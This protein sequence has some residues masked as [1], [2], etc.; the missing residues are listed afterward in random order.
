[1]FV[2]L[3]VRPLLIVWVGCWG[4]LGLVEANSRRRSRRRRRRR[5][6][7]RRRRRSREVVQ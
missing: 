1:M 5:I 3:F 7:R 2:C 6:W 4:Q